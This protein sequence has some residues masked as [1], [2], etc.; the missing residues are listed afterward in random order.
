MR[1]LLVTH[2]ILLLLAST[3]FTII[4]AWRGKSSLQWCYYKYALQSG[5]GTRYVSDYSALEIVTYLLAFSVGIAGFLYALKDNHV[6]VGSLGVVLSM[7]GSLSFAF[8][9]SHFFIEHHRSCIAFSP[10]VMFLLVVFGCLPRRP[11]RSYRM[12]DNI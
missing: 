11:A 9:G 3:G 6:V 4:T 7:I 1:I 12:S 5:W 10:A 2:A 8:E